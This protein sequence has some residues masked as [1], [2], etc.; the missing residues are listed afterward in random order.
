MY[1]FIIIF[2]LF[3]LVGYSQ[4]HLEKIE[5]NTKFS[6]GGDYEPLNENL[7]YVG[8]SEEINPQTIEGISLRLKNFKTNTDSVIAPNIYLSNPYYGWLDESNLYFEKNTTEDKTKLFG[9][10][11]S[12]LIKYNI[13]THT[14]TILPFYLLNSENFT[15]MLKIAGNKIYYLCIGDNSNENAL[16]EYNLADRKTRIIKSFNRHSSQQIVTY[17]ILSELNSMIYILKKENKTSFIK[18]DLN[19][20]K[21]TEIKSIAGESFI[22]GS[23]YF[24]HFFYYF[25]RRKLS[26]EV[27][28]NDNT[29]YVINSLDTDNGEIKCI[30]IFDAG[31]EITKIDMVS[32]NKILISMQGG[33]INPISINLNKDMQIELSSNSN[34][35]YLKF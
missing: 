32:S 23:A 3:S 7:I 9:S 11:K 6:D 8:I 24:D 34:L 28:V 22:D 26:D 29:V 13:H 4:F 17:E 27:D 12:Q 20:L 19:T 33:A 15:S 10:S 21:E 31:V 25:E 2:F 18:M 1:K 35:Y 30:E 14:E 16:Y 5:L